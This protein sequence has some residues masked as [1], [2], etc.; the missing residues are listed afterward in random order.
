MELDD[1][2]KSWNKLD[3]H[4][5]DKKLFK[6]EDI[7]NLIEHTQKGISGINRFNKRLRYIA[8]IALAIFALILTSTGSQTDIIYYL[9]LF[10][11]CIP[12]L[13]WDILSVRYLIRTK[14]DEMPI[15][16]VISRINRYRRWVIRERLFA[17]LFVLVVSGLFFLQKHL[18]QTTTGAIS[19]IAV[20]TG[21]IV[22]LLWIYRNELGQLRD[23]KK[24]LEELNEL[25]NQTITTIS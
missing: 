14:V 5:K 23:I 8:L 4:L 19:Y 24:N 2:K 21:S 22:L 17:I 25:E 12:A 7:K 1:L 18:W 20:W 3:E 11:L 9:I 13:V 15:V 16:T 6:D 10:L